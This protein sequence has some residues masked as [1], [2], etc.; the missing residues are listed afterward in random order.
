MVVKVEPSQEY[1]WQRAVCFPRGSLLVCQ[2]S[3]EVH[4]R[5]ANGL[6]TLSTGYDM[7][8]TKSTSLYR[9]LPTGSR[10]TLTQE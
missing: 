10:V 7:P 8:I 9:R 5:G 2:R 3:D 6:L 4:Y 1:D